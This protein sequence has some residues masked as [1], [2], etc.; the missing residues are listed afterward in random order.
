M[1]AEGKCGR[2]RRKKKSR[3][4]KDEEASSLSFY[5]IRWTAGMSMY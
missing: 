1:R 4:W 3:G 2:K 5:K